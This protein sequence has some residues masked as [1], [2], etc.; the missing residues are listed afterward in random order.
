MNNK[1]KCVAMI[2]QRGCSY[3]V[4]YP[5]YPV[6]PYI[7]EIFPPDECLFDGELSSL[8]C[9]SWADAFERLP[10]Y[11]ITNSIAE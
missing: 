11:E 2:K 8:V 5:H 1:N 7:V 3:E 10:Q 9:R 6:R 4:Q